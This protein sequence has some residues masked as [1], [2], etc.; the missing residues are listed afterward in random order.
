MGSLPP[1]RRAELS[2]HQNFST[3]AGQAFRAVRTCCT[4]NYRRE[5]TRRDAETRWLA[6]P[7]GTTLAAWTAPLG[8]CSASASSRLGWC[9][10]TPTTRTSSRSPSSPPGACTTPPRC[11]SSLRGPTWRRLS[12]SACRPSGSG[13]NAPSGRSSTGR[14]PFAIVVDGDV[15]GLQD[16]EAINYP[17]LLEASTG[18]WLGL[19]HQGKGI[20]KEMRAAILHFLFEGLGAAY[21]TSG[22]FHDNARS[23]AVSES[24]GYAEAGRRRTLRR[25]APDWLVGFRLP[26]DEW[27][28]RRRGDIEI[29]GLEPCLEMFGL[30]RA[31]AARIC[32]AVAAISS[33]SAYFWRG[34]KKPRS[35]SLNRRGTT[36]T[37]RWG[38]LW[39][40]TLFI[41]TNEP[42]GSHARLHSAGDALHGGE[43]GPDVV[44]RQVGERRDVR[45]GHDEDV[46]GEDA[47]GGRGTR[48]RQRRRARPPPARRR[49]RWRRRHTRPRGASITP[50]TGPGSHPCPSTPWTTTPAP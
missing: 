13:A 17:K 43:E 15:V 39:L 16:A 10:A 3:G 20:G 36:C 2:A 5:G 23:I 25:D 35:P 32:S 37:W 27:E 18:S 28:R 49:R 50:W 22:A 47:G 7:L 34:Q 11:P 48:P 44:D 31:S 14:C 24:L 41:A 1:G 40:T 33:S 45:P 38:T 6:R 42:V 46:A 30:S 12:N 29:E 19:A 21:A 8:P 26:R 9:S 4:R